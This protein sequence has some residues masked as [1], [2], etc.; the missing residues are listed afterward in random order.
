MFDIKFRE[1]IKT[2][3]PDAYEEMGEVKEGKFYIKC[4]CN[5]EF[6]FDELGI[7]IK[8]YP[9]EF[10]NKTFAFD[11]EKYK[12][13]QNSYGLVLI[14]QSDFIY[15]SRSDAKFAAIKKAFE[16]RQNQFDY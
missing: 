5:L 4:Y 3:Y 15:F 7:F 13:V 2:N 11:V 14:F 9:N 1:E 12:D 6:Y 10:N 16:I 8:T